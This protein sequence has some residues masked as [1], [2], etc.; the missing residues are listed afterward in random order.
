[1]KRTRFA[2]FLFLVLALAFILA[3]G[4]PSVTTWT[5]PDGSTCYSTIQPRCLDAIL[6]VQP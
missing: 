1:M 4:V 2:L 6:E 3:C 5:R